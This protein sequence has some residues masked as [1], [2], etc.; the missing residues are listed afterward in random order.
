MLGDVL[1]GLEN[2]PGSGTI[3]T[4]TIVYPIVNAL[5][6]LGVSL[7]VGSIISLDLYVIGI[8][9]TR[10]WRSRTTFLSKVA[11]VG[12][13]IAIGTG[14][15]LFSVR[16]TQYAQDPAFQVKAALMLFAALNVVFFHRR[17]RRRQE[18]IPDVLLK[19]SAATSAILWTSVIFA[20][21]W[22]A[23]TN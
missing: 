15:L 11:G 4:S 5:H 16:A 8:R 21:R 9:E 10:E 2:L 13:V 3:R 18:A 22:I 12:L 7:L 6:I 1:V 23:F 20:G 17:T 14:I 19:G